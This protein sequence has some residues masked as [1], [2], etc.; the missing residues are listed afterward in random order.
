MWHARSS[1]RWLVTLALWS[2]ACGGSDGAAGPTGPT[3]PPPGPPAASGPRVGPGTPIAQDGPADLTIRYVERMPRLDYV[4]N[5]PDPTVDGW[6]SAGASVT[7]RAHLKNWSS[8]SLDGVSYAWSLDGVRLTGGQLTIPPS[9]EAS[10]DFVWIWEKRRH[11]LELVVDAENRYTVRAGPRNRL[12]VYTD[13]LAIGLYVER[14]LYDSFRRFQHE[15]RIGNSSFEDWAQLQVELWNVILANAVFPE[16]P[17]GVLDRVR[18]DAVTV[19]PDGALP[20]D[21]QAFSL[22]SPYDDPA[23]ARPNVN[24]RA[25]DMQ[26]GLTTATL[27][28]YRNHT[29]LETHNQFYYSGYIQH[30]MGHARYLVDVYAWDVYHDTNGSR[31]EIAEGGERVAG[32]RYMP[33]TSVIFNGVPGLLLH[34]TPHQGLMTSDW[35]YVDRYSA[36]ALN[37]IAGQRALDGN[38][39]LPAN[40]GVFLHDLPR[41]NLLTVRD[42]SN[43]ALAN[44]RVQLFRATPG[45]PRNAIYTKVFD[46]RPDLELRADSEGQVRLGTNPFAANGRIVMFTD[47]TFANGTAIIRVEHEGR[48]GYGFL[49]SSDFNLEYWRGRRELGRYELQVQLF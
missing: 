30:E 5:S 32:S 28:T 6:P 20:L 44:A 19:V 16:T 7:W 36:V 48:V 43:R 37:L 45:D 38:Y 29:S 25:V 18:L 24:D 21:P 13:A 47:T 33:G 40:N 17:N 14:G 10:T 42:G 12:R 49:E 34:R 35:H 15:L 31:V 41:E 39:Y 1:A 11:E 46:A 8:R 4:V 26:W 27:D 2:S 23:Q 22:G 3:A 9:A